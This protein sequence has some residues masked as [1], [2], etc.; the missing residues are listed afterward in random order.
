MRSAICASRRSGDGFD[1]SDEVLEFIASNV[2]TISASLKGCLISLEATIS[3]E[4]K[5]PVLNAIESCFVA[6]YRAVPTRAFVETIQK[7]TQVFHS[8]AS[9][10]SGYNRASGSRV[11][12]RQLG[13]VSLARS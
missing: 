5:E 13:N 3:L 1:I 4:G 10:F 11:Q 8:S 9:S 6:K 2:T 12:A 7:Y